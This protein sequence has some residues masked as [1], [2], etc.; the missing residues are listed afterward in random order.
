MEYLVE[1]ESN[2]QSRVTELLADLGVYKHP[3]ILIWPAGNII[4]KAD[5]SK[6]QICMLKLSFNIKLTK[7]PIKAING[8]K[9]QNSISLQQR[10][11]RNSATK[12]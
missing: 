2:N 7:L 9:V 10:G 5:L 12:F 11:C 3:S 1:C 6:E 8:Y 4:F